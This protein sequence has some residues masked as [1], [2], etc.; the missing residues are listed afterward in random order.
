MSKKK[1]LDASQY[2]EWRTTIAELETAKVLSQRTEL[3]LKIMALETEKLALRTELFKRI[4]V[5]LA[6]DKVEA[7]KQEYDNT[8][9]R[10]EGSLGVSLSNKMIDDVTFEVKDLP[11]TKTQ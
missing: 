2:W 1:S 8:K 5:K 10:L 9:A 3:E 11:E 7:A 6:R 4:Q